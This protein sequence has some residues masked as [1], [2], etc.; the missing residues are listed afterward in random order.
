MLI[1]KKMIQRLIPVVV[2]LCI[3]VWSFGQTPQNIKITSSK[4]GKNN[5]NRASMMCEAGSIS[6][7]AFTGQ[8]DDTDGTRKYLCKNDCINIIHDGDAVIDDP[9]TATSSGIGYVFYDFEP[10]VTGPTIT[11]V[12]ND[13]A[14]NKTNPIF[15]FP[16]DTIPQSNGIWLAAGQ[17][18]GDLKITNDC[19]I[20]LAFTENRS[21]PIEFWFAPIT[22]HD[23]ATLGFETDGAMVPGCVDVSVDQAFSIVYL[24][25]IE[26]NSKTALVG[27]GQFDVRRGLPEFDGGATNYTITISNQD[28]PSV[29]GTV[30][31]GPATEGSTVTFTVPQDG[32]YDILVEDGKSCSAM[33][34][35]CTYQQP[36]FTFSL[37]NTVNAPTGS[38]ICVACTVEG[39][40]EV[41]A[42][43]FGVAFD[44]TVLEFTNEVAGVDLPA[45]SILLA[46]L[47][48]NGDPIITVTWN[49]VLISGVNLPNGTTAFELCFNVIGSNGSCS[50]LQFGNLASGNS[51]TVSVNNNTFDETF[52]IFNNG[53]ICVEATELDL[54]FPNITPQC[55]VNSNTGGFEIE[56]S[57][58]I[59]P[60][61]YTIDD[62]QGNNLPGLWPMT[63]N[64]SESI[65]GLQAGDY[66]IL[67]T[68]ASSPSLI[69]TGMVSIPFADLVANI[70]QIEVACFQEM[71]GEATVEIFNSGIQVPNDP[72]QFS[73]E[74]IID[75]NIVATTD[76]ASN[77]LGGSMV[78]LIVT[79]NFTG[80]QAQDN[81]VVAQTAALSIDDVLLENPDCP[82]EASG[83]ITLTVSGGTAPYSYNWDH[84]NNTDNPVLVG[85][86]AGTAIAVTVT[87]SNGC[88][89]VMD[90]YTLADPAPIG[91]ELSN[92]QDVSCFDAVLCDGSIT[93]TGTGGN[94]GPYTFIWTIDGQIGTVEMD[95]MSSTVNNLCQG[96]Q[97][98]AV[99]EGNCGI[100]TTFVIGSPD[101]MFLDAATQT[102]AVSCNGSVDGRIKVQAAGGTPGYQYNWDLL[103][104]AVQSDSISGLAPGTYTVT[105]E[106]ANGCNLN[107][108]L[109]VG[110]P[111]PL[112][113][114]IDE[115]I[116]TD[117]VSC[118]GDEDGVVAVFFTGGNPGEPTTYTWSPNVSEFSTA[119]GLA[120]GTYTVTVTDMNGCSNN[121]GP[122]IIDT[123]PPVEATIPQPA[124]PVCAEGRTT[125]AIQS[126]SGGS[127]G[128][129]T[130]SIN[131]GVPGS[132]ANTVDL[133]AGEYLVSVFDANQCTYEE[134]IVIQDPPPVIVDLGDDITI[135]LGQSVQLDGFF[136]G[137]N[138]LDLTFWTPDI[139][140]PDTTML[141]CLDPTVAPTDTETYTLTV[142]DSQ[143]CTGTDDIVIEVDVDRNVYIPNA[144]SPDN[145][146][147]NDFFV[148]FTGSGVTNVKSMQVYD[149]WGELVFEK[150]G[151]VPTGELDGWNGQFRGKQIPTGVYVYLIEVEFIDGISLLYR[152]SVLAIY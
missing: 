131:N 120:A 121:S 119:V 146:G 44:N 62:C 46:A 72:N 71:N 108:S 27:G 10:T 76:T 53:E 55:G 84:P 21:D 96:M 73:Y 87:D 41:S 148:P 9:Q 85:V 81:A 54:N 129:Y 82:G 92:I 118:A 22:I 70:D 20:Q 149:R 113:V 151:F 134:T 138:P 106:D 45:T 128:P 33:D 59:G 48:F 94:G 90:S 83:R 30:T 104:G 125:L 93:A 17:P 80:C 136:F 65:T 18:N 40:E 31:S 37:P 111:D 35:L 109:V 57:Q 115:N 47:P 100:D 101:S 19:N 75:G 99:S 49:D 132:I 58:G 74:W 11:D 91:V 124:A 103:S 97:S 126:A 68:D 78:E 1:L 77:L 130:F 6:F 152:G 15:V 2:L 116:T 28:D 98:V 144:F 23:F 150:K 107:V 5:I 88:T 137:P 12:V 25:A 135:E 52:I 51:P 3:S 66:C 8:S 63:T 13:P 122:I 43:D 89:P 86:A 142:V 110:E 60:Y 61:S 14:T 127:G 69:R 95:V 140:C 79:D 112:E 39:F 50:P 56:I 139:D 143:G 26:I 105:V 133:L 32:C 4:E 38:Q 64:G 145:D 67:V 102:Y 42:F 36:Q 147:I 34:V 24:N 7:G 117:N 123:P 16:N 29:V 141:V 114:F